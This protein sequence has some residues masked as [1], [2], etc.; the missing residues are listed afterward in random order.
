MPGFGVSGRYYLLK[1]LPAAAGLEKSGYPSQVPLHQNLASERIADGHVQNQ[2]FA[3]PFRVAE[4]DVVKN[5]AFADKLIRAAH[6]KSGIQAQHEKLHVE[7]QTHARTH[8]QLIQER[9][10]PELGSGGA[11][12]RSSTATRCQHR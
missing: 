1:N 7:P 9:V 10:G 5:P 6:R 12:R 8:R 3:P 4:V 2:V 11:T